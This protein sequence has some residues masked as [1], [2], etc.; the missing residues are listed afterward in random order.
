M[1]LDPF[2]LRPNSPLYIVNREESGCSDI[3]GF[4][5]YF[6]WLS[7][8]S[9]QWSTTQH[10]EFL[11]WILRNT[12]PVSGCEAAYAVFAFR[13]SLV[14]MTTRL[15]SAFVKRYSNARVKIIP[16]SKTIATRSLLYVDYVLRIRWISVTGQ[17][18]HW[19]HAVWPCSRFP[20]LLEETFS[21]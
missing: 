19:I 8:Q 15:I 3:I 17:R 9:H 2:T 10:L 6:C 14:L 11:Q 7:D 4:M 18:R 20:Y 16:C 12:R 1:R 5:W 13:I 21:L